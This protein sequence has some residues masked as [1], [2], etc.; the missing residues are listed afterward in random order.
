MPSPLSLCLLLSL[1]APTLRAGD[2]YL[3]LKHDIDGFATSTS[4]ESGDLS[5]SGDS[6]DPVKVPKGRLLKIDSEVFGE[7][8]FLRPKLFGSHTNLLS[9]SGQSIAVRTKS[10]PNVLFILG[11]SVGA[12]ERGH[13]T[14]AYEGGAEYRSPISLPGHQEGRYFRE[15]AALTLPY[16]KSARTRTTRD[17]KFWLVAVTIP[18]AGKLTEF[19]LP[20]FQRGRVFGMT[21]SKRAGMD[22]VPEPVV[23][24]EPS[25][26][27]V[28]IL[29]F[30][31][32]PSYKSSY[33]VEPAELVRALEDRG[34]SAVELDLD[35]I[36]RNGVLTSRRY[37]LLV[38]LYGKAF[39]K[40]GVEAIRRYR[41]SAGRMLFTSVPMTHLFTRDVYGHWA[42]TDS[43]SFSGH[44]DDDLGFSDSRGTAEGEALEPLEGLSML[45][46]GDLPWQE[47]RLGEDWLSVRSSTRD[48]LVP[49]SDES[50]PTRVTPLVTFGDSGQHYAAIV[51][52]VGGVV[53]G[54][55]DLWAG[56]EPLVVRGRRL[57]REAQ[58]EWLVRFLLLLGS[59]RAPEVP[60]PAETPDA[61]KNGAEAE[62]PA[63]PGTLRS[64]C[65]AVLEKLE[66]VDA[67]T[68]LTPAPELVPRAPLE[69]A[70]PEPRRLRRRVHV[71]S[72]SELSDAERVLAASVQG[73]LAREADGPRLWLERVPAHERNLARLYENIADGPELERRDVSLVDALD[74]LGHRR[75]VVVDPN[76]YGSLNLAT[77]VAAVDDLLIAYPGHVARYELDVQADLR[78]LFENSVEMMEFALEHLRPRL[79]SDRLAIYPPDAAH[80]R[81]RD[82][83]VRDRV[84]VAWASTWRERDALGARRHQEFRLLTRLLRELPAQT[85][86]FGTFGSGER[87]LGSSMG[88]RLLARYGLDWLR[89]DDI[90]GTF[91]S[92]R[93]RLAASG[94]EAH[95]PAANTER[96]L[97]LAIVLRPDNSLR[98]PVFTAPYKARQPM[99]WVDHPLRHDTT[100]AAPI[101][102][103]DS[104]GLEIGPSRSMLAM[105]GAAHGDSASRDAVRQSWRQ[106]IEAQVASLG[107]SFYFRRAGIGG[108][109]LERLAEALPGDYP[110]VLGAIVDTPEEACEWI[111]GRPVFRYLAPKALAALVSEQSEESA[112]P[113]G[114]PRP[115]YFVTNGKGLQ[116]A[117][118]AG[119]LRPV[120]IGQLAANYR[121]LRKSW[122]PFHRRLVPPGSEWRYDAYG[123]D[124]G[125]TWRHAD[126]DD[127]E[128]PS[129][130]AR[131]GFGDDEEVTVIP[132]TREG[133]EGKNPT[134]YFRRRFRMSRDR[135]TELTLRFQCDDGLIIWLNNRELHRYN[136]PD[137][138]VEFATKASKTISS[139]AENR[140][141]VV[142]VAGDSLVEG[143]NVLAVEVHQASANSSD[144]GFDLALEL[145]GW[146]RVPE[147][148]E[149]TSPPAEASPSEA[150][151]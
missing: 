77:M 129:G 95:E 118:S 3:Y 96:G 145:H 150:S 28:A 138:P 26:A 1:S 17:A 105:Q 125:K 11:T 110:L 34:L 103:G 104:V 89:G 107:A 18:Q 92:S 142:R 127:S 67:A 45:L 54:V 31:A 65:L 32:F 116:E 47:T 115:M 136:L 90:N 102:A 146:E 37:P 19:R 84:F 99:A 75:A 120:S 58:A 71:L 98:K 91:F 22:V 141:N 40:E 23:V 122:R 15:E 106:A 94:T 97:H 113:R 41:K 147:P 76:L 72:T 52:H 35:D 82:T 56:T 46:L 24:E 86:C 63:D 137:G 16:R 8:V 79:R 144:L 44:D 114:P 121:A 2:E 36:A 66:T 33:D 132:G 143:D 51:D 39:P 10:A 83:L 50:P 30:D 108:S 78:G 133:A 29:S 74:I 130:A 148:A 140:W 123:L 151:Q 109:A 119:P 9:V 20:E 62:S 60:Q 117:V 87:G 93:D 21:L 101:R 7:V 6:F 4:R 53:P 131:L 68:L 49:D 42:D 38:N 139:S 81:Q 85:P 80:F 88:P 69:R 61:G 48:G 100:G 12:G 25:A 111:A 13:V 27:D 57:S 14:F 128:W 149:T 59:R 134:T 112:A 5:G 70:A 135:S 124:L 64:R 73:L 43:G 126:F 55:I